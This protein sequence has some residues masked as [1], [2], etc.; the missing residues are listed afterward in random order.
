MWRTSMVRFGHADMWLLRQTGD[1][2]CVVILR[3]LIVDC[4]D[5]TIVASQPA[6]VD[7]TQATISALQCV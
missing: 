2:P 3:L 6:S 5:I 4:G 1:H 7:T